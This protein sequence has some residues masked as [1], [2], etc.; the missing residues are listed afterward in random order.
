[1]FVSLIQHKFLLPNV[2]GWFICATFSLTFL[3]TLIILAVQSL[4][5][6]LCTSASSATGSPAGYIW[7][8]SGAGCFP[9]INCFTFAQLCTSDDLLVFFECD[10]HL[11]QPPPVPQRKEQ[12]VM[13]GRVSQELDAPRLVCLSMF[14]DVFNHL[15]SCLASRPQIYPVGKLIL[16]W[17][18]LKWEGKMLVVTKI[19]RIMTPLIVSFHS[20]ATLELSQLLFF[21]IG[22]LGYASFL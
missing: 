20:S 4:F 3:S 13:A 17:Y 16:V 2:C 7:Y 12:D 9:R 15:E 22:K 1:M 10:K 14:P 18:K 6:L 21:W 19:S 5:W 8:L 11:P